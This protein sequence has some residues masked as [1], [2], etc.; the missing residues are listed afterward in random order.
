[1]YS[2]KK[3]SMRTLIAASIFLLTVGFALGQFRPRELASFGEL[4]TIFFAGA[5][6][7]RDLPRT[8]RI[9]SESSGDVHLKMANPC[10]P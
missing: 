3:L 1:M 2:R 10:S 9:V 8:L 4:V 5:V 6:S 7:I